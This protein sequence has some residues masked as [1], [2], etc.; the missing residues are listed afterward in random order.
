MKF[1][2][3]DR[4]FELMEAVD[5]L[6]S[7]HCEYYDMF[8]L[9]ELIVEDVNDKDQEIYKYKF[10]NYFY[11]AMSYDKDE[12]IEIAKRFID[13]YSKQQF[14]EIA[15][16]AWNRVTDTKKEDYFFDCGSIGFIEELAKLMGFEPTEQL[17]GYVVEKLTGLDLSGQ[18][19]TN[20][21]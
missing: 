9:M 18:D 4:E 6:T 15:I 13:E 19:E 12:A 14:A 5:N 10:I 21:E 11:G 3:L 17:I 2:Y 1:E 16:A 7:D 20:L 8:I